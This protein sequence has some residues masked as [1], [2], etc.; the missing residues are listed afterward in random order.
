[1]GGREGGSG[2]PIEAPTHPHAPPP[3]QVDL[4]TIDV[5]NLNRQFL[6]R[7]AHVGASKAS[8]AAASASRFAPHTHITPHRADVRSSPSFTPVA[9]ASYTLIVNGLDNLDARRHVNRCALAAR[10]PLVESGSAGVLGQVTVHARGLALGGEGDDTADATECYECAPKAPPKTFPV[11]TIRNTPDKPIHAVVWA[12]ELLYAR[13]L[14]PVDAVTD[15]DD[16]GGEGGGEGGEG[17]AAAAAAA[18][19]RA[20]GEDT[21]TYAQRVFDRVF[22]EDVERTRAMD[23]SVFGR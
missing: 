7:R 23:V 18:F 14:G 2:G 20:D 16:G 12:K 22:G 15:L 21:L 4:D 11:C 10:V 3:L 5:S 19:L 17:E 13:L 8:V 6:F 9:L 1:M